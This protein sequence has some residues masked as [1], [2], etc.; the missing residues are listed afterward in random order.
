MMDKYQQFIHKSRY[1]RWIPE[2]NRRETW[3]ETVNR[4]VNFFLDR[5]QITEEEGAQ[6]YNAIYNLEVMPSMRCMMTAGEA[7]KRDNVAGFNCSYLHIAHPRCF[8]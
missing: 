1:A 4:Y 3:S 2:D 6:I 5:E 7:L 8:D